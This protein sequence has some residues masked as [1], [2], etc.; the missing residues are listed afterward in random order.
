MSKKHLHS[1]HVEHYKHTAGKASERMPLPGVVK[2][3]MSQNIGKP[4][5][6]LV[7]VGDDVKVGQLIGDVDAF[8]SCPI[9]SSVSG[10]VT[11]IE[12][13]R[14]AIMGMDTYVVIETDGK[15]E[16]V[17]GITVPEKPADLAA[18]VAEVRKSGIVGLGGASFP[19]HIKLNPKNL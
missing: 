17:E 18:F 2:L 7:K 13:K 3:S 19:T 11:A 5:N 8:V 1:I 12:Q 15:Q 16:V 6:P 9:Y 10:K 4:C 14:S